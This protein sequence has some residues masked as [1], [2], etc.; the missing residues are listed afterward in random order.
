V[1]V[2]EERGYTTYFR[3]SVEQQAQNFNGLLPI[4]LEGVL[5]EQGAL[6]DNQRH[7]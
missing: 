3:D 6:L 5:G 4:E 7:L 1:R 2:K